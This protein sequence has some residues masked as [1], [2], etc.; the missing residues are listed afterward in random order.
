MKPDDRDTADTI[1]ST[2]VLWVFV[3]VVV[4]IV[5]WWASA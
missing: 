2:I 4:G 5:W 1:V 3:A